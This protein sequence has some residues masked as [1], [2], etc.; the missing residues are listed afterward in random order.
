MPQLR[1]RAHLSGSASTLILRWGCPAE[2]ATGWSSSCGPTRWLGR[3]V[4]ADACG[5]GRGG[6]GAGGAGGRAVGAR[7]GGGRADVVCGVGGE[8]PRVGGEKGTKKKEPRPVPRNI[9]F[10]PVQ[11]FGHF[12]NVQNPIFPRKII[13]TPAKLPFTTIL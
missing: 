2:K 12:K 9:F 6:G 7:S 3:H 11:H 4:V 5:G 8:K 1:A 13:S 10:I